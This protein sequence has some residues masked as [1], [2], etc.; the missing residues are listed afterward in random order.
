MQAEG[1]ELQGSS[2]PPALSGQ[3]N[4]DTIWDIVYRSPKRL[5]DLKAMAGEYS[6]KEAEEKEKKYARVVSN[7]NDGFVF[8]LW[9]P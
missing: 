3:E 5:D 7:S 1:T 2:E 4:D 6:D 9:T 8:I